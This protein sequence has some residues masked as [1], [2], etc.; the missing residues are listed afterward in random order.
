M[1]PGTARPAQY[2]YS[3]QCKLRASGSRFDKHRVND[4]SSK[5][6]WLRISLRLFFVLFTCVS[7]A[8]AGFARYAHQRWA[9]FAAIR[10]AG[11]KV[12]MSPGKRSR[13]AT[14]F[15]EDLFG[16]VNNVDLREGKVDN[17]LLAQLAVLKELRN[18]DLSNADIDDEGL[19]RL[20][21]LPLR[22]LWLQ[23]TKIT[24][25]SAATLSKISFLNFLQLN[26]TQLSDAFLERLDPLPNLQDLGLRGTRVT[27]TGMNRLSRHPKLQRLD[28]YHTEVDDSGVARLA[29]CQS[30]TDVGLSATN[31]T[32]A[33]FQYLDKL[34]HLTEADLSGNPTVTTEAVLAFEKSHPKCDIEWYGK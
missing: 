29:A 31:V 28:L 24:D 5:R 18:L 6:R 8:I 11:G 9:A 2:A 34:P 14:W 17:A 30:L 32:D 25:A 26:A 27:S 3:R 15:G 33:V 23:E 20:V 21:H 19:R 22:R 16:T 12:E 10:Q 7:I 1:R 13:L 4:M